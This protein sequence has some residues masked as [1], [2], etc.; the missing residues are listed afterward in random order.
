M[1][2]AGLKWVFCVELALKVLFYGKS[3][4]QIQGG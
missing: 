1:I 3:Y 4:R 2:I